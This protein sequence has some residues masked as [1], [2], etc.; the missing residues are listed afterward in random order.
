MPLQSTRATIQLSSL[1]A[2]H[3]LIYSYR[4]GILFFVLL[5]RSGAVCRLPAQY[6]RLQF[7]TLYAFLVTFS[8]FYTSVLGVCSIVFVRVL[9]CVSVPKIRTV[10]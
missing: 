5:V 7:F 2:I 10:Q 3:D 9:C 1:N 4:G 8:T 6:I